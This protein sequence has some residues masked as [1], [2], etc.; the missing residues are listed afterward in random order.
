MRTT[1]S[2]LLV[3][4][5]L[6]LLGFAAAEAAGAPPARGVVTVAG[7]EE[8]A[9]TPPSADRLGVKGVADDDLPSL[10]RRVDE[11][12]SE[13]ERLRAENNKLRQAL[14]AREESARNKVE[15]RSLPADRPL[16][17]NG[18]PV[19][20]DWIR[21]D[22]GGLWFYLVPLSQNASSASATGAPTGA[23]PAR[24]DTKAGPARA[25]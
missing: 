6:P 20:S 3:S 14:R 4:V 1:P 12:N 24:V 25:R 16:L 8:A 18:R 22:G 11:L 9:P 7:Q 2:F 19:P 5:T 21:R 15:V 13:V 10:R 17:P 23:Q